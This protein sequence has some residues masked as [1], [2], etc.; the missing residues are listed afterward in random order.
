[1]TA[2]RSPGVEEFQAF[3]KSRLN[4]LNPRN[5]L[6][7]M[8]NQVPV[9]ALAAG[10]PLSIF[11]WPGDD[12]ELFPWVSPR[13]RGVLPLER[14]HVGRST[15][16]ALKKQQFHVTFDRAFADIIQACHESHQPESWIHPLMQRAY[17]AAH[18]QG[19]AHSVEVWEDDAL[20]GGLYGID[21][22]TFFSGESMFH[23]RPNA[24]KA[25]VMALVE[26]TRQRGDTL[27]DIQQCT[28]HMKVMGAE[29]WRRSRFI[30]HIHQERGERNPMFF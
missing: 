10:Y 4:N 1:M 3:F 22:G 24:G 28:P 11:P 19:F 6:I 27:L 16:R 5:E 29:N 8:S 2:P 26:K 20:V 14:F 18:H 30:E 21:S 7:W 9:A 15:R 25:A 17:I 23:R 12:P 13:I